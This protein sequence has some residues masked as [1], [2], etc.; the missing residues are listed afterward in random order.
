M[1]D[2]KTVVQS[3]FEAAGDQRLPPNASLAESVLDD[4]PTMSEMELTLYRYMKSIP[5]FGKKLHN[6]KEKETIM[7]EVQAIIGT[8]E[9]TIRDAYSKLWMHFLCDNL[10]EERERVLEIIA[11]IKTRVLNKGIS[12]LIDRDSRSKLKSVIK[13]M[14]NIQTEE[15][16][17]IFTVDETF[18]SKDER[19]ILKNI[20][21]KDVEHSNSVDIFLATIDF[22]KDEDSNVSV[23]FE[24]VRKISNNKQRNIYYNRY[25]NI[26]IDEI[27]KINASNV[28]MKTSR[29]IPKA[30]TNILLQVYLY[31][32]NHEILK[33]VDPKVT[34]YFS[35]I[36]MKWFTYQVKE[37]TDKLAPHW[38]FKTTEFILDDWQKQCIRKI[39][40]KSNILLCAPT[41]SGKTLLS[42]HT[43]RNYSKVFFVVPEGALGFQVSGIIYLDLI[44]REKLVGSIRKNV[45]V[46]LNS[47]DYK[48]FDREDDIIISTPDKLFELI[49]T[50]QVGTDID[51]IILDEF[52]NISYSHG[53]YYEYI[54]NF[55]GFNKIPTICLSATI[56]NYEATHSWLS[57][58][59][60]GEVFG[61]FQT[62]RFFNQ[63]R[64]V[65]HDGE[66]VELNP[67]E[68]LSCETLKSPEFTHI[69]LHPKDIMNLYE[70]LAAFSRVPETQMK[71]VTLDDM[72]KIERSMFTYLKGLSDAELE[73]VIS[74]K[75]FDMSQLS[76]YELYRLL[77]RISFKMKP[78]LIFKFDPVKCFEIYKKLIECIEDYDKLVYDN[79][80]DDIPIIQEYYAECELLEAKLTAG[81]EKTSSEDG[82]SVGNGQTR[83]DHVE[84]KK[85][86]AKST[87]YA[88]KL[89]P[90]LTK[91]YEGFMEINKAGMEISIAQ[92]NA[93][94]GGNLTYAEFYRKR[95]AHSKKELQKLKD[96]TISVRNIWALHEESILINFTLDST[97]VKSIKQRINRNLVSS[98]SSSSSS[99][100]EDDEDFDDESSEKPLNI[101]Y[102]DILIRGLMVGLLCYTELILPAKQRV[103]QYLITKY[104]FITFSDKS[105]AVGMNLPIK[106]VMLLG[107][108]KGEPIETVDNTLA[109]QAMGRAGR[110]GLDKEGIVIYSG[111]NM[112]GILVHKYRHIVPNK[113]ELIQALLTDESADFRTFIATGE[114]PVAKVSALSESKSSESKSSN[115][116]T[117]NSSSSNSASVKV[118]PTKEEIELIDRISKACAKLQVIPFDDWERPV[119]IEEFLNLIDIKSPTE[120]QIAVLLAIEL[121]QEIKL[122]TE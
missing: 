56:P 21:D 69:G 7:V 46:K 121:D 15:F 83:K 116:V 101:D 40:S 96:K 65:I 48:R 54:L 23:F 107:G 90:S 118:L 72:E 110:R 92:F 109:H 44:E 20:K 81:K 70:S 2:I 94:Y 39:D 49:S 63:K 34:D 4:S 55:A 32:T 82:N 52:H 9:F 95:E 98:N 80:R 75:A 37:F 91:F 73:S 112:D 71:F 62:K 3:F 78:M 19:I 68:H 42:T 35:T 84:S 76:I 36:D 41:S 38:N 51:Y 16:T 53:E 114:R 106:A 6:R 77:Q 113:P 26:I 22:S 14:L 30:L 57:S 66:L 17:S 86:E 105:L 67:L 89:Y 33:T 85:E 79:F 27:N 1:T 43:I 122:P 11:V 58:K 60:Y 47:M 87:L 108:M 93:K 28:R 74:N 100:E 117:S 25:L 99:K 29:P 64:L 31:L 111:V 10:E 13:K 59:L 24:K 115:S 88:K 102:S 104:K 61:I 12:D 8:F 120:N 119:I 18:L 97:I 45:R 103:T 50:K 5:D